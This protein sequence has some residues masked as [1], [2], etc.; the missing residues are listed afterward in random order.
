MILIE[1]P[2]VKKEK[3]EP[4]ITSDYEEVVFKI[5]P[6]LKKMFLDQLEKDNIK[7]VDLVLRSIAYYTIIREDNT[8][9]YNSNDPMINDEEM[10]T[11]EIRFHLKN[12][13]KNQITNYDNNFSFDHLMRIAVDDFLMHRQL[14]HGLNHSAIES[15]AQFLNFSCDEI[16]SFS[17]S[18]EFKEKID[19]YNNDIIPTEDYYRIVLQDYLTSAK[20]KEI[21]LSTPKEN[22]YIYDDSNSNDKIS[23]NV[24]AR[25]KKLFNDQLR[26]YGNPNKDIL[27]RAMFL[28][29]LQDDVFGIRG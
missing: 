9:F 3:Y 18:S 2:T 23:I 7:D 26:R 11:D 14:Q 21:I 10:A 12:E 17:L 24:N 1:Y 16:I 5:S 15:I 22:E 25:F 20:E 28:K 29:F 6:E 4:T 19:N 8:F 13:V 27:L